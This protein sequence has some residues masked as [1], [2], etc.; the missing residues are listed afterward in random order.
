MSLLGPL[1]STKFIKESL[2]KA[3]LF[4]FSKITKM[5]PKGIRSEEATVLEL[6][7][8]KS[9]TDRQAGC[10]TER[11]RGGHAGKELEAT[12]RRGR[13]PANLHRTIPAFNQ[14]LTA[15]CPC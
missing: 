8:G 4:Y 7:K 15:K 11:P 12:D 1:G 6:P 2:A 10:L 3:G 5:S 14:L 9:N 13:S